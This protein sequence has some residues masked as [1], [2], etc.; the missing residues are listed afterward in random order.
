M[1]SRDALIGATT[2]SPQSSTILFPAASEVLY[3]L[4]VH[5]EI[6]PDLLTKGFTEILNLQS[7]RVRDTLLGAFLTSI[8]VRE[9]NVDEVVAL[10]K[11]AFHLD[12]FSPN[13]AKRIDLPKGKVL[14]GVAGSGKKGVKT[15]NISTPSALIAAS[16]DVYVAK[17]GSSST[18]SVIGSA[19]FMREVGANIDLS[20]NEMVKMLLKT[21]FGFFTIENSI[22]KF[23]RVYSGRFYAP[24]VLS[25]GLPALVN[26]VRPDI[27]LY[28]L[29]HPNIQLS[30][31]VLRE[32]GVKNAMVVSCTDDDIH[33]LD[34]IGVYGTTKLI[35]MRQG[36]IGKLLY[37]RPTEEIGLPKYT[38]AD[39]RQ[40]RTKTA[41][42]KRVVNAL[43]GSGKAAHED[44]ISMNAANL[45]YLAGIAD[46]LKDGYHKAREVLRKGWPLQKLEEFIEVSGG[47]KKALQKY[48]HHNE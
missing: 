10:L 42:I 28:G 34:E 14:I 2:Q 24:H 36:V 16:L 21:R 38:P 46:N 13:K 22:P 20:S 25:F 33:F 30:L 19:D 3:R 6:D 39:I 27:V 8:M 9:P 4:N 31:K 29:A 15:I 44:I 40:E 7:E 1:T 35:S 47:D 17:S 12:N 11:A 43:R 48:L 41:N 23:D 32:F 45:L 26:P 37:F 5:A 18:S